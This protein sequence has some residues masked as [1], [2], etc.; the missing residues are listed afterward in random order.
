MR[1][2]LLLF[3]LLGI[4]TIF[5]SLTFTNV[6]SLAVNAS[7]PPVSKNLNT[8]LWPLADARWAAAGDFNV[9]YYR[10]KFVPGWPELYTVGVFAPRHPGWETRLEALARSG[11]GQYAI[12]LGGQTQITESQDAGPYVAVAGDT[13][14]DWRLLATHRL[15]VLTQA[16]FRQGGITAVQL[17][18][19]TAEPMAKLYQQTFHCDVS[20]VHEEFKHCHNY[21]SGFGDDTLLRFYYY[22]EGPGGSAAYL[23][24]DSGNPPPSVYT[25]GRNG[26]AVGFVNL[27]QWVGGLPAVGSFAIQYYLQA[28]VTGTD[29]LQINFFVDTNGDGRP[30]V[31]VIYYISVNGRTPICLS[32]VI[33]GYSVS[34]YYILVSS[35]SPP[36]R[37]WLTWAVSPIYDGGL[38]VGVAFGIYSPN[39]NTKAWWDNLEVVRCEPPYPTYGAVYIDPRRSPTYPPSL[40]VDGRGGF[41]YALYGA[42][43]PF[44]VPA[45]GS[46][47]R[48]W[49]NGSGLG[50][51][52]LHIAVDAD[53]D[54]YADR[55]YIYYR[56]SASATLKSA[57]LS[58]GSDVCTIQP[59][60]SCHPADSRFVAVNLGA[61]SSA[62]Q[63]WEIYT[64]GQGAVVAVAF[65]A[66]GVYTLWD[67]LVVQYS[68]CP[69][70]GGW[71]VV[72]S[73][74]WQSY[75]YLLVSGFATAYKPLVAGALTYVAN[76][77]G[78]GTYAIFD[79]ALNP[80]FGVEIDGSQ[81]RALCGGFS[82]TLGS[83]PS[84]K[85]VELRPLNGF[86]DIITRDQYGAILARY[87]CRYTAA[88]TYVGFRG[89]ALRVYNVTAFG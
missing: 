22:P 60:G 40:A 30:D 18:N 33:Y 13:P 8:S 6:I 35:T 76:F 2:A 7:L 53:G 28:A 84:A 63:L 88:P 38:V 62:P 4:A 57:V 15:S 46:V 31:E 24:S 11:A 1:R 48:V 21:T 81:L 34:C 78:V 27:S 16:R 82:T 14:L 51:A 37:T 54:G 79:S 17:I 67:D 45:E 20:T 3:T 77:T 70:P 19:F 41:S 44:P 25:Q 87:G 69:P 49:A 89:G 47:F 26:Y 66:L 74:V 73:Y 52:A 65:S 58:P 12:A 23:D 29:Y 56:W 61:L 75:D 59:D 85:W 68:A 36:S 39:G 10:M 83:L 50:V 71:N 9:T 72:G 42:G 55:E 43:G 86:G 64:S 80:I 32:S 5:A